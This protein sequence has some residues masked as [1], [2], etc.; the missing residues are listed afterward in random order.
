MFTK[1]TLTH[2]TTPMVASIPFVFVAFALSLRAIP[3][4]GSQRRRGDIA[5]WQWTLKPC[6]VTREDGTGLKAED[7][8]G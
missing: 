3:R 4:R 2:V 5:A 8:K 1:I 6:V 7:Q